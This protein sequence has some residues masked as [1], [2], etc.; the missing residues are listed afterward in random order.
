LH[1]QEQQGLL[2]RCK[3]E[4]E[5]LLEE[6]TNAEQ[7]AMDT[8]TAALAGYQEQLDAS[9]ASDQ[10]AHHALRMRSATQTTLLLHACLGCMPGGACQ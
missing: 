1:V 6:R 7:A 8:Y 2:A 4:L 9:H 5:A 10:D 3:A